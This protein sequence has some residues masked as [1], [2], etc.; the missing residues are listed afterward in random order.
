MLI[1]IP[2][3]VLLFSDAQRALELLQ[4]Y[5]TKL[6][7]RQ[8]NQNRTKQGPVEEDQ[9]LQQSL[10]RV[11]SVF[12]SQLFSALLGK[13]TYFSQLILGGEVSFDDVRSY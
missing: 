9:Q 2:F 11:I 7:Q 12:Q 13:N 6:D 3:V 10:D 8:Q 5:R 4:Q 1:N